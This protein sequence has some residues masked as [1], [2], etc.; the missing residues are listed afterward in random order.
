MLNAAA[1]TPSRMFSAFKQMAV[2]AVSR[3]VFL[4]RSMFGDRCQN[5]GV[6]RTPFKDGSGLDTKEVTGKTRTVEQEKST[7]T[8][9]N[10][11]T[12]G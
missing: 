10:C 8:R 5:K 9:I 6:P 12:A 1:G 7:W 3:P 2:S 4:L 11:Y